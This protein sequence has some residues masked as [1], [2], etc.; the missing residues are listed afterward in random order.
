MPVRRWIEVVGWAVVSIVGFWM[1]Y[2]VQRSMF[3]NG[4]GSDPTSFPHPFADFSAAQQDLR[5][6]WLLIAITGA[7]YIGLL[8]R[9][10][11]WDRAA[12]GA[13]AV[14]ALGYLVLLFARPSLS[15][16]I[17][18]Y[19]SHGYWTVGGNPYIQASAEVAGTPLGPELAAEGWSAVHGPTPYGP[20]WTSIEG[21]AYRWSG[22]RVSTGL[23]AIKIVIVLSVLGS[24]VLIG[25]IARRLRPDW[26]A[27]AV[28]AWLANP[29]VIMEFGADGHN[30]APAIF[31]ALLA[32]WAALRG[33]ALVAVLALALGVLT[34]YTPVIFVLPLLVLLVRYRR[35]VGRLVSELLL[36][37]ALAV[38]VCWWLWRPWWVGLT[39]LAGIPAGGTAIPWSPAGWLGARFA[40]PL[41]DEPS[42]VPTLILASIMLL[43]V[44]AFSS[45]RTDHGALVGCAGIAV[46]ALAVLPAYWPWYSGMALALLAVRPTAIALAQLVVITAG[47]RIAGP[48]GDLGS[49]GYVDFTTMFNRNALWGITLP[50]AGVLVL[51]VFSI[52]RAVGAKRV[53]LGPGERVTMS[54]RDR[55]NTSA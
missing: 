23:I 18:S 54:A 22:E 5:R 40:D 11:H 47:S 31:F 36:G 38:G 9:A 49:L 43:A 8:V 42:V 52:A 24:A 26:T 25:L 4:I 53:R 37:L 10:R 17:L 3:L 46:V 12:W 34:K 2:T 33:W 30:D 14:A 19:L 39:T 44:L 7:A 6:Y 15:I 16:D 35:S 55:P 20:L 1:L 45:R 28:L 41:A 27:L 51:T 50:V 32:I 29:L 13:V 48:Y 21:L